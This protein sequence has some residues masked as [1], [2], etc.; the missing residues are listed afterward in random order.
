MRASFKNEMSSLASY[1]KENPTYTLVIRGHC[2]G[3]APRTIIAPG[4]S[5][6]YFELTCENE[7]KNVSAQELSTLR[8]ESA[9]RYLK[10][11]GIEGERMTG[12]GEAGKVMIYP[13][14]SLYAHYNDR[15]EFEII[16]PK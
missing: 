7:I 3:N 14:T 2:N 9:R 1:L 6:N 12:V 10:G 11:Q 15:I 4:D 13:L 5:H 8:A 16:R